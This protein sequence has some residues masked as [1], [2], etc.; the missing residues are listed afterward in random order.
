MLQYIK[1]SGMLGWW[2]RDW[3]VDKAVEGDRS[4]W[5]SSL[6]TRPNE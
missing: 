1:A 5:G 4:G 6:T 2:L 3:T